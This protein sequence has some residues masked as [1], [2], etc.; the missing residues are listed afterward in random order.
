MKVQLSS[1]SDLFTADTLAEELNVS[2][3]MVY[4]LRDTGK[5]KSYQISKTKYVFRKDD[6]VDY[7]QKEKGYEVV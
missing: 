4:Y 7:L 5:L 6:V 1:I 3:S 2:R